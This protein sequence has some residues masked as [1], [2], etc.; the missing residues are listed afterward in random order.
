ML[1]QFFFLKYFVN[2]GCAYLTS[3]IYFCMYPESCLYRKLVVINKPIY[4]ALH[5]LWERQREGLKM[6]A[7]FDTFLPNIFFSFTFPQ[8][9]H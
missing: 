2:N 8:L 6:V 3:K 5:I 7:N 9:K 4:I 1:T